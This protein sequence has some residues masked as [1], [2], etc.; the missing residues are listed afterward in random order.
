MFGQN[1]DNVF[2]TLDLI[3]FTLQGKRYTFLVGREEHKELINVILV[4]T[5]RTVLMVLSLKQILLRTAKVTVS[6]KNCNNSNY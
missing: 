5:A 4:Q 3:K 1:I 2:M 6:S